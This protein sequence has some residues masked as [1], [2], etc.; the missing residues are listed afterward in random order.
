MSNLGGVTWAL[1]DISKPIRFAQL[2]N[3]LASELGDQ[4]PGRSR[5]CA[6]PHEDYR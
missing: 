4:A 1:P 5:A 3:R 2:K 6:S